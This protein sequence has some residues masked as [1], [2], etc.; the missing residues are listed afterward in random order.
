MGHG[1]LP[2]LTRRLWTA[3]C[4]FWYR[5]QQD[6]IR[7]HIAQTRARWS[8][9]PAYMDELHNDVDALECLIADLEQEN[10]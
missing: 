10:L 7:K 5:R 9:M 8:A 6:Q 4:I 1:K 2:N 3:W